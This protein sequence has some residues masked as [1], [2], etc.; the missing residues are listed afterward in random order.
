MSYRH[1]TTVPI[2]YNC[3]GPVL[4]K[5]PKINTATMVPV[6]SYVPVVPCCNKQNIIT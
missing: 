6:R 4:L 1:N 2:P 5:K 3:T